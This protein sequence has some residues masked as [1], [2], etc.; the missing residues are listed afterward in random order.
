MRAW[1][2]QTSWKRWVGRLTRADGDRF[3]REILPIAR[4]WWPGIAQAPRTRTWDRKGIDLFVWADEG[5]F[6]CVIQCK[7]FEVQEIGASQIA[8]R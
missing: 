8:P 4:I 3:E 2:G 1:T 7:G 6:P 5:R